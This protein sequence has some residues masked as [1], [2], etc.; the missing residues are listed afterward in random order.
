MERWVVRGAPTSAKDS[1]ERVPK[2][3]LPISVLAAR[4]RLNIGAADGKLPGK[5]DTE[6]PDTSTE[7]LKG[8]RYN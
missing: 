2:N 6:S 1:C 4:M 5:G 8:A 7:L 3:L